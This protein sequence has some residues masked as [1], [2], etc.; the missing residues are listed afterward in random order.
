MASLNKSQSQEMC[1]AQQ[2]HQD[3]SR[4]HVA[5]VRENHC[6]NQNTHGPLL[7]E[8]NVCVKCCDGGEQRN[9]KTSVL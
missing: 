4:F 1:S 8:V 9:G 3:S 7:N 2:D 6:D 5:S